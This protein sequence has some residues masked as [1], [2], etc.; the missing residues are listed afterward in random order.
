MKK[1]LLLALIAVGGSSVCAMV[2]TRDQ[3]A[4]PAEAIMTPA[5]KIQDAQKKI[6][7]ESIIKQAKE[8]EQLYSPTNYM[9]WVVRATLVAALAY[10]G[11]QA[12]DKVK[13]GVIKDL[14]KT[15]GVATLQGL[16]KKGAKIADQ[17][18]TTIQQVPLGSVAI[19]LGGNMILSEVAPSA[20]IE[21]KKV[22]P[23][24][25]TEPHSAIRNKVIHDFYEY[26]HKTTDLGQVGQGLISGYILSLKSDEALKKNGQKCLAYCIQNSLHVAAFIAY[27]HDKM[28]NTDLPQKKDVRAAC[29]QDLVELMNGLKNLQHEENCGE[30]LAQMMQTEQEPVKL[31]DVLQLRLI[32]TINMFLEHAI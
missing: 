9:A 3:Q 8:V 24:K 15:P 14:Q 17:V 12:A 27:Y 10:A 4:I 5:E 22:L 7:R 23:W 20:L 21:L 26:I 16:A 29:I 31:L 32:N 25:N 30:A 28:G 6:I 11:V 13:P 2:K 18:H 19:S 1:Y